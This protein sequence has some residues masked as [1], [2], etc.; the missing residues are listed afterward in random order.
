TFIINGAERVI[1]SQLHKSPG[2]SFETKTHQNGKIL[3]SARII[4]YRGAWL[5][6]EY[7]INDT[8]WLTIDRRSRLLATSFLKCFGYVENEDVLNIFYTMRKAVLGKTKIKI[9]SKSFEPADLV[10]R[11]VGADVIDPETGEILAEACNEITDVSIDRLMNSR[12]KEIVIIDAE[13]IVRDSTIFHTLSQD[14]TQTEEDALR[15]VYARIRPG[16]PATDA[17]TRTFFQRLFYDPS[18]YDFASVG[19]YKINRKLGLEISQE[20]KTLGKEDVVATLQYLVRLR[21]GEGVL[22]DIDHL[23]NRRV[24]CVG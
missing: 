8:L 11:I 15:E 22:D 24:R 3:L 23:G 7:D 21:S 20:T 4:P 18:R 10:G 12:V 5:E 19:R 17:T 6:F 9:G 14:T 2:V 13:D 1:V 16:D